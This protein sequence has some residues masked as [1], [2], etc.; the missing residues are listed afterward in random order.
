MQR[1]VALLLR[2]RYAVLGL[3]V[4]ITAGFASVLPRAIIATNFAEM[5]F[6]RDAAFDRYQQRTKD[7]TNDHGL[8]IGLTENEPLSPEALDRLERAVE[9]LE[10]LS[11]VRRVTSL[12]DAGKLLD[13]GENLDFLRYAEQ[14]RETPEQAAEL[15]ARIQADPLWGRTILSEDGRHTALIVEAVPDPSREAEAE[16]E[17]VD[18][19]YAV[20]AEAGYDRKNVHL[21]GPS[22]VTAEM[23]NQIYRNLT[24]IF[25]IVVIALFITGFLMFRQLWPVLITIVVAFTAVIWT[26]GFALLLDPKVNLF[27]SVVPAIILVI[28]FSDVIH[29]CSAYLLELGAGKSKEEAIIATGADVG[30]ACLFTSI[31]TFI[32]FISLAFVP[33]PVMQHTGV[34]LG[35]G[36]AA[37]LLIAMTL[38]PVVFSIMKEPPIPREAAVKRSDWISAV[39]D[40][41]ERATIERPRSVV[42]VFTLLFALSIAGAMNLHIDASL[43]ERLSSDNIVRRDARYIGEHFGGTSTLSVFV[44]SE[45][46]HDLL[47]PER[48]AAL[49]DFQRAV[50][51]LPHV[52]HVL[53]PVDLIVNTHQEMREPGDTSELPASRAQVGGYLML[54][55]LA[56]AD[57][58]DRSL[59]SDR[60]EMQLTLRLETSSFRETFALGQEVRR[61]GAEHLGT[62]VSVEPGG[63]LFFLGRW[64]DEIIDGQKQGLGFSIL[65]I[66]I[67]MMLGLRSLKVGAWSMAPNLIPLLVLGAVLALLWEKADS[68]SL[69]VA[70]IAI[71]IGVDDTIHFL[72]RYKLAS[73]RTDDHAVAVRETFHFAG[74]AI[75]IT[76]I[77]LVI[78]FA[79]LALSDYHT[80][81]IM[82]TLLPMTLVMALL[83]NLFLVPALARLGLMRFESEKRPEG[84]PLVFR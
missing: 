17:F 31:T 40:F 77:I 10:D 53:S 13:D 54:F 83:A 28:S 24:F 7:M 74:R 39:L 49:V 52:N 82:G 35:F 32:G 2:Y 11:E 76:S 16:R 9:G 48:F 29:L 69:I 71:G 47:G 65:A 79:P 63:L 50:S 81:F 3:L 44:E 70:M 57:M 56:G 60:R 20:F 62:G 15:I 41:A 5:F 36:V 73:E 14:A 64:L 66:T 8:I 25:P 75:V 1:F 61:L 80:L 12:L 84:K 46:D 21:G 67:M 51:A 18:E 22:A 78:G 58:L 43:L 42:A 59:S 38:A 37:T 4:L 30:T 33:S 23:F 55:E 68:D 26:S 27:M 6:S 19:V 72:M 45:D 34:V